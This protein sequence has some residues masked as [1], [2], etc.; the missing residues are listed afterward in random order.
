MM[1]LMLGLLTFGGS[2]LLAATATQGQT[3]A[4]A[5]VDPALPALSPPSLA[6]GP[7]AAKATTQSAS[8]AEETAREEDV[9]NSK[10]MVEARAWL[11][12][13]S[14]V[15]K[16]FGPQEAKRYIEWLKEKSPEQQK[17]WL[18][19]FNARRASLAQS[20][21]V[22]RAARQT[23]V[24][25]ALTRQ[26]ETQQAYANINQGKTAGAIAAN[27]RLQASQLLGRQGMAL[28][29]YYDAARAQI[30]DADPATYGWIFPNY[31]RYMQWA[32]AAALPGDLPRG[33]PRNFSTGS[34]SGGPAIDAQIKLEAD[35]AINAAA[36]AGGSGGGE[37]GSP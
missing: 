28:R 9:W 8:R 18:V 10:E 22:A 12:Q 11:A 37:G 36:A 24:D 6:A 32:A 14:R 31:G 5:P 27:E 13:R 19:W 25:H 35:S 15:S 7:P 20:D 34:N 16:R 21:A 1:K 3:P 26:Q 33:D 4:A 2:V 29:D 17:D 23:A 30:A